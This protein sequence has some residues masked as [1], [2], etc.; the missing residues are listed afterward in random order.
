[1]LMRL[2]L[3]RPRLPLAPALQCGVGLSPMV[4]PA[5]SKD[6]QA[7]P[8]P[9]CCTGHVTAVIIRCRS[10][11]CPAP[12]GEGQCWGQ[13]CWGW[14]WLLLETKHGPR[15]PTG[16]HRAGTEQ[17]FPPPGS[18]T[19]LPGHAV[20]GLFFK[21]IL[22][23]SYL[24]TLLTCKGKPGDRSDSGWFCMLCYDFFADSQ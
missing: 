9:L 21:S 24:V 13:D 16:E 18:L 12:W 10:G 11:L 20:T 22:S 7:A 4:S 5:G 2:W 23:C 14:W 8:H 15:L 17:A 6:G 1:M 3:A 19:S